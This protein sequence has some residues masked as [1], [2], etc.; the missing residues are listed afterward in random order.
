METELSMSSGMGVAADYPPK[1]GE[2]GV[3]S[4]FACEL[5]LMLLVCVEKGPERGRGR[6]GAGVWETPQERGQ[7]YGTVSGVYFAWERNR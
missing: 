5:L 6:K 2:T 3:S 7:R 1:L 4:W